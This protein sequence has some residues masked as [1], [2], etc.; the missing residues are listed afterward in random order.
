MFKK[1][2]LNYFDKCHFTTNVQI[3]SIAVNKDNKNNNVAIHPLIAR[4]RKQLLR[5]VVVYAGMYIY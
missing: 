4:S 2:L 5:C 3:R 1:T